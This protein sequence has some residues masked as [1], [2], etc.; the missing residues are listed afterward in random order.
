MSPLRSALKAGAQGLC[1]AAAVVGI[2]MTLA[3]NPLAALLFIGL[4][5]AGLALAV[6]L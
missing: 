5:L 3:G 6:L 2:T 1:L 4:S